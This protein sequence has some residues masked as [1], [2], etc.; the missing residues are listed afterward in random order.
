MT[1]P[2]QAVLLE[3][4]EQE[5]D[6]LRAAMQ[7]STSHAEEGKDMALRLGGALYSFWFV[8]AYFS[9]GRDFWSE[10]CGFAM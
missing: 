7:W 1:G 8:R 4:L 5:H 10:H 2:Q 9:E 6:N 3:R